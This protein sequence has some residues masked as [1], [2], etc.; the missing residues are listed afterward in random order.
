MSALISEEKEITLPKWNPLI[1]TQG[2]VNGVFKFTMTNTNVS[3]ANALRRTILSDIPTVIIK[4]F[5]IINNNTQF[6]N[7]IL[8]Q[9]LSM[10]PLKIDP[11][12]PDMANQIKNLQLIIEENNDGAELKYITTADFMLFE[13]TSEKY[14]ASSTLQNIFQSNKITKEH[15]LFC[16]LKPKLSNEIPGENIHIKAN[17]GIGTAAEKGCYNVVSTCAYGFTPDKS[18]IHNERQKYE[19]GLTEKGVIE[20]DI[21]DYLT[22]WDNHNYKRYYL[23]NSFDFSIES[24]GIFKE[25]DIIF[26]ACNIIN[27]RLMKMKQNEDQNQYT[28]KKNN[29]ALENSVDIIL[30]NTDYTIGKLLEFIIYQEYFVNQKVLSFCG[31]LKPHP[32]ENDSIVRI[33]FNKE[34]NFTDD[35]I[36]NIITDSCGV[37]QQIFTS[38]QSDFSQ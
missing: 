36:E 11:D 23:E 18:A 28:Y 6:N 8:E 25:S 17:L 9:R 34:K 22:N 16:R 2:K 15:I 12:E 1:N 20:K 4:D 26:K 7:Q 37:G 33:A 29:V 13:K 38:I 10:I 32:H 24:I 3:I 21:E 35:N 5:N 19:D 30:Y 31:F 27:F 14:I